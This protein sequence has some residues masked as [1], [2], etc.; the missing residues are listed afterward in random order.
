RN[1]FNTSSRMGSFIPQLNQVIEGLGKR[2]T[3]PPLQTRNHLTFKSGQQPTHYRCEQKGRQ[4]NAKTGR[5]AHLAT[6]RSN[7]SKPV[8]KGTAQRVTAPSPKMASA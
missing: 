4:D 8:A 2:C 1:Y 7:K 6:P 3:P 5:I